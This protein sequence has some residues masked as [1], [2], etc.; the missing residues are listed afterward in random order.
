MDKLSEEAATLLAAADAAYASTSLVPDPG[1]RE[2]MDAAAEKARAALAA[3]GDLLHA[4][5][6]GLAL[7]L[8]P[9]MPHLPL[10]LIASV[11]GFSAFMLARKARTGLNPRTG[12]KIKIAAATVPKFSAGA[13]LKNVVSGAKKLAPLPKP[14]KKAASAASGSA[15]KAAAPAKKSAAKKS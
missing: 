6:R 8:V 4:R 1:T 12:E 14:A 10:L 11:V 2:M 13:D 3:P 9:G 5:H 15:K 7:G